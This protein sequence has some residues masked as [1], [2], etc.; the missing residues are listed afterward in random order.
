MPLQAFLE[1]NISR[2]GQLAELKNSFCQINSEAL[3]CGHWIVSVVRVDL[4]SLGREAVHPI[5]WRKKYGRLGPSELKR[6]K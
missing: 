3:N 2:F 4:L 6:L 1:D 5:N